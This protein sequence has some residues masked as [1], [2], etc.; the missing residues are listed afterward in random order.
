M[1]SDIK[2]GKLYFISHRY[3]ESYTQ[4]VFEPKNWD[5][6]KVLGKLLSKQLFMI[7]EMKEIDPFDMIYND[8]NKIWIKILHE[9]VIGWIKTNLDEI[10]ELNENIFEENVYLL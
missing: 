4:I 2:I 5:E 8:G 3:Y 7:L 1:K 10:Y 6:T 9:D